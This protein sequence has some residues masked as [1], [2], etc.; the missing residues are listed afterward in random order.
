M[1]SFVPVPV[2]ALWACTTDAYS[3]LG[4]VR[5]PLGGN[6]IKMARLISHSRLTPSAQRGGREMVHGIDFQQ[7]QL[8]PYRLRAMPGF[9]DGR[10]WVGTRM[11]CPYHLRL[12]ALKPLKPVLVGLAMWTI[13]APLP[14]AIPMRC[15][16]GEIQR[17]Q[18]RTKLVDE[19][20][21]ERRLANGHFVYMLMFEHKKLAGM[22]EIEAKVKYTQ[23]ARSLKTYGITFFLVKEKVK[24]KNKL[25]PR[26]LGITKEAVVRVD[27]KT[28]ENV[29]LLQGSIIVFRLPLHGLYVYLLIPDNEDLAADNG[30]EMGSVFRTASHWPTNDAVTCFVEQSHLHIQRGRQSEPVNRRAKKPFPARSLARRHVFRTH[31]ASRQS[32]IWPRDHHRTPSGIQVVTNNVRGGMVDFGDYSDSYYSVQTTEG[33]QISQLIAGYIDIILKKKKAKDHLGLEGDEEST[34]YE[35]SVSPATATIIRHGKAKVDHPNIGSVALPAILRAGD[36][37][38]GQFSTGSMQ[39]AQFSEVSQ[40]AHSGHV[41]PS[42]QSAQMHGLGQAQRALLGTI[43]N[44]LSAVGDAQG[45]LE[46]RAD[47]PPLGTDP[48]SQ[49]WKENTRDM[50]KQKVG[51]QLSAMNAA[52]A[53]VVTLTSGGADETDYPAVG[54]AVQTISSNIGEFSKDVKLLAALEEEETDGDKLLEAARRLAGAFTDLLRAAQP[55]SQEPR[56]NLLNAASRIGEA[57][58]DIMQRVD[59]SELDYSF[60][61]LLLALAK[62][63]ANA[64]ASLVLKAKGVASKC[65]NQEDQN[66]VIGTATQCALATSQ[67]VACTKVVAP[68]IENPACQEQLIE[69]AKH[70][71]KNVDC[72]V[73]NAQSV[74]K[75]EKM[76]MDLG[77]AATE[78]TKALNDLLNHIKQGTG[79]A[80]EVAEV[81]TILTATDR[82]FGSMGD[83][84]EMVKQARVLAQ[85]TSH[86][87]NALKLEAE[88]HE[89][90]DQQ[91]KLLAAARVLAD[92]TA[93]MVEAAKASRLCYDNG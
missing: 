31:K 56:Q 67:L 80:K 17:H 64:T 74:C 86:L 63:V 71:A 48:A 84:P 69:A 33:E 93:R 47:L 42:G 1:A 25:V 55:G 6:D 20:F 5:V 39:Q 15:G 18:I 58:H 26:L 51:S 27:E 54:A 46:R 59:E 34:M 61:D 43:S 85:A 88:R 35:H 28:K 4:Q 29:R 57:S 68:T 52:T 72:V 10:T 75:D 24:G 36:T 37:G 76:L 11:T 3:P 60:E 12:S 44:G 89:D 92:A 7:S 65:E 19:P 14:C 49:Q 41:P 90:S 81:D 82:L 70:V 8:P 78:V 40:Q 83:T 9:V 91:K 38:P 77:A 50:S 87:V 30:E 79:P 62:A 13:L 53:Q 2:R 66:K 16:T 45:E 22:S 21:E 73:E 32:G 23:L